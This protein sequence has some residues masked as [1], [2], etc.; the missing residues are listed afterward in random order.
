MLKQVA[1]QTA[2]HAGV[3][4][5]VQFCRRSQ[6]VV[7]TFHR[8]SGDGEGDPRGVPIAT[9]AKCLEYLTRHYRVVSLAEMTEGL[10]RGEVR[11]NTAVV[12]IDDGY[13]EVDSMGAPLLRRYRI[14]ASL[15]VVSEFVDGRVWLWPDRVRFVFEHAPSGPV[16]FSR[17]DFARCFDLRTEQGRWHAEQSCCEYAKRIP[18]ADRDELISEVAEACGVDLPASPP[19]RYRAMTWAQLRRLAAEGLDV[20]AHTRT[21]S[22]LSQLHGNSLRDEIAGCKEDIEQHLGFP[23]RHFAYPNGQRRDYTPESVAEVARAGYRAAVTTIAGGNAAGAP[24]FELRRIS[25]RAEEVLHF[26]QSVSGVDLLKDR[27]RAAL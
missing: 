12:T 25:E 1:L 9:L 15:F 22:I 10:R 27:L 26:A 6:A 16:G 21:H 14:P 20:G 13:Y 4:R 23:V 8:F 11:P 7:L 18:V 24:I 5:L 19:A 3:F 2:F 17:R